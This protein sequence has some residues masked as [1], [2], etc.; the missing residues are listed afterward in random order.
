MKRNIL[1]FVCLLFL[2]LPTHGQSIKLSKSSEVSVLTCG[3][4]DLIHAIYGHTAIRVND[5][6]QNWDVVFN[7]GVFSFSAPN[8][9]YRFAK[10]QTDYMLAAEYYSDFYDD[11][12][13]N[14]RSINEQVLNFTQAEKQQLL[15]FLITNAEPENREY[16]YNFFLDNCATRVRDV[17]ENQV[18]GSVIFQVEDGEERTFRQHVSDY[19]KVLP[20]TNFGIELALGSPAD[21]VASAYQEMF[22]PEYLMKHFATAEIRTENGTRPLVKKTNAIYVV[23]KTDNAISVLSPFVILTVLLLVVIYV[24]YHQYRRKI[25]NYSLDYFLL[26]FTGIVGIIALW[27]VLYSEHPAMHP[28]YNMWWAVPTNMPFLF[29]WMVKKWRGHLKWY[30]VALSAWL[31]V[32]LLFNW[33][34]PQSF[35]IGFYVIILMTLLRSLYHCLC[36]SRIKQVL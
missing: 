9:A 33:L 16:R 12:K 21:E 18:D 17:I 10:G 11:Y 3:T 15:D 1:F 6:V 26:F 25:S 31:I 22:L 7:Y 5:P 30:W 20:W 34:A 23:E 32:F 29:L 35:H 8:F 28:N 13:N 19:Q 2:Y 4:S 24:T 14:G 27:F 36:F